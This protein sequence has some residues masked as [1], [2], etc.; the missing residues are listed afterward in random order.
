MLASAELKPHSVEGAT[1]MVDATIRAR[2]AARRFRKD[3][4]P[5]AMVRDILDVA[6]YAPS[7]TNIQPWRAWVVTGTAR[8]RLC[9]A[10]VDALLASGP[11]PQEEEYRYYPTEF[12]EA[13]LARRMAFGAAFGAVKATS[14]AA[15]RRLIDRFMTFYRDSLFKREA[16]RWVVT[17]VELRLPRE[18]ALR[19][20]YAGVREELAAMGV[21]QPRAVHVAEAISR[22]RTRKLPNPALIGNAGS[23]FKNPVVPAAQAEALRNE[24][25][26]LPVY[27]AGDEALRKISA[28]WLIEQAGWKGFREGDAGIAAQ[29]ALVLVNHGNAT[30]AQLLA[31]ARRVAA[32]VLE[33]FGVAL[34]PEPRIIGASFAG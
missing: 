19:L 27:P 10:T 6:R 16:D 3:P 25:P 20:D 15:F 31:L 9:A 1:D 11:Q 33:K 30:G 4:V 5:A 21:E 18:H 8:D 29:H 32:S 2:H 28:A 24:H 26:A 17:A 23:F 12:P 34:E 7:G 13:I 22:I 14:D